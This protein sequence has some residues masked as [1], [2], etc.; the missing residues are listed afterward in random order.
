MLYEVITKQKSL[1][2]NQAKEPQN[3]FIDQ[4]HRIKAQ[5][6]P[7]G[8]YLPLPEDWEKVN[9]ETAMRIYQDRFNDAGDF[10]FALVGSFDVDSIKPLLELYIASLPK[11]TVGVITSYSIHYTKLYDCVNTIRWH[12]PTGSILAPITI[13]GVSPIQM[14]ILR[15]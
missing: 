4:Y 6:H 14:P 11:R 3:Y 5:N 2:E 9:F 15:T 1:F 13:C 7:R 10:T 8:N 12:R